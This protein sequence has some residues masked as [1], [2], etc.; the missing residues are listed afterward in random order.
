M[1]AVHVVLANSS[2]TRRA[3]SVGHT[4]MADMDQ[5]TDRQYWYRYAI[6]THG[7]LVASETGPFA[8][9]STLM[10]AARDW[11]DGDPV[12]RS[13]VRSVYM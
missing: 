12:P 7:C 9:R 10:S 1:N 6:C 4:K 13:Q 8:V 2:V 3:N 11:K 5:N